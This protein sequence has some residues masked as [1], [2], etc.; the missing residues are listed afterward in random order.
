MKQKNPVPSL[1]YIEHLATKQ[2][3]VQIDTVIEMAKQRSKIVEHGGDQGVDIIREIMDWTVSCSANAAQWC[4]V[5]LKC[6]EERRREGQK[7][8]EGG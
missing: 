7:E 5:L 4:L 1:D 8:A 3:G 2:L 6:R